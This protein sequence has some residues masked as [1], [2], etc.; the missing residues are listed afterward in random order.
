MNICKYIF[1]HEAKEK[2]GIEPNDSGKVNTAKKKKIVPLCF[3]ITMII[4]NW[5][6]Q[7]F[8]KKKIIVFKI[9]ILKQNW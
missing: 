9:K 4:Q 3:L 2:H 7:Q 5:L 1:L 6:E 8:I